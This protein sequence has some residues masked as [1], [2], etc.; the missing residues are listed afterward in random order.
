M[1]QAQGATA[2][3]GHHELP[4][5]KRVDR[6]S[7]HSFFEYHEFTEAEE[8]AYCRFLFDFIRERM[9]ADNGLKAAFGPNFSS[10]PPGQHH[11][12]DFHI[13]G[14]KWAVQAE[15]LGNFIGKTAYA[16]MNDSEKADFAQ[17][18]EE[19][20]AEL[21]KQAAERP[22]EEKDEIPTFRHT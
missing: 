15:D 7:L 20:V 11:G 17:R 21:A 13:H 3:Q 10:F 19:K 4:F 16:A 18:H 12:Q 9:E 6:N 22:H 2:E 14:Y 8:E 1:S 5:T